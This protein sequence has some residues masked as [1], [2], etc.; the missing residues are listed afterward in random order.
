MTPAH[1]PRLLSLRIGT[2]LGKPE[3]V[4]SGRPRGCLL[5]VAAVSVLARLHLPRRRLEDHVLLDDLGVRRVRRGL[6]GRD[7]VRDKRILIS[8]RA[9]YSTILPWRSPTAARFH[10]GQDGQARD[11]KDSNC[12]RSF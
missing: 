1:E 3:E 9:I 6:I 12:G 2:A 5:E 8:R 10:G 7:E 11:S 4:V